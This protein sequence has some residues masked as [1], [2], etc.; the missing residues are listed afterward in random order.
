MA[1]LG[2]ADPSEPEGFRHRTGNRTG[3]DDARSGCLLPRFGVNG[4]LL[5]VEKVAERLTVRPALVRQLAH[6]GD[7]P[8]LRV[9]G[10]LMR[11]RPEDVEMYVEKHV[12]R[13]AGRRGRG[14]V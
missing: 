9:G 14:D 5:T 11:F 7:L 10:K 8:Y 2:R 12:V 1:G 3:K 13:L 4:P 6:R